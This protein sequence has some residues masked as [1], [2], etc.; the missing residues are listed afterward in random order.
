MDTRVLERHIKDILSYGFGKSMLEGFTDS[1]M[2]GDVDSSLSTSGYVM[3]YVRGAVSW[4]QSR[5]R[6][7]VALSTIEAKYIATMVEAKKELI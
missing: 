7:V 5:L 6:K 4:C 3:T 1:N 2:S